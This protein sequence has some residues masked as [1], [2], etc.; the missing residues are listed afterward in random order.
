MAKAASYF[1]LNLEGI[2][3]DLKIKSSPMVLPKLH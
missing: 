3:R 2:V 1:L